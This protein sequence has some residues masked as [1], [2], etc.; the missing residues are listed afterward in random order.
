MYNLK[1][2]GG[3]FKGLIGECMFKLTDKDI[4]I[5][6]FFNRLKYLEVFGK[7]L[8]KKQAIFISKNWY[9]LDAVKLSFVNGEKKI[10]LYEVKTRNVY[11]RKIFSKPKMTLETHK[12]YNTAKSLGF[13][14]KLATVWLHDCWIY[15]IEINELNK[16]L[17]CIDKPKKYDSVRGQF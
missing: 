15:D 10:I 12:L 8:D 7:Y 16:N 4:I 5:T 1:D 11:N 2:C 17:Y 9:S 6:R 14:T 3:T 13:V